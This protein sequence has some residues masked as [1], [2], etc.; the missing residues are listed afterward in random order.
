M[1]IFKYSTDL[2]I[3]DTFTLHTVHLWCLE[4]LKI[5][6]YKRSS[7]RNNVD[8]PQVQNIPSVLH[9]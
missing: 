4:W 2:T 7:T 3:E 5:I 9:S 1:I 8:K 6:V